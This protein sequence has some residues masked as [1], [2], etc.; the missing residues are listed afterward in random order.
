M[1][2]HTS[3]TISILTNPSFWQL[4]FFDKDTIF[5]NPEQLRIT[6]KINEPDKLNIPEYF[7]SQDR[8]KETDTTYLKIQC[9]K[10]S[11]G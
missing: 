7:V 6:P 1:M 10:F 8:N 2:H 5:S 3:K 9:V 4:K 11:T